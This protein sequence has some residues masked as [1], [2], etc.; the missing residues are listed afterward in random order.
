MARVDLGGG[1]YFDPD[2]VQQ[3]INHL[4]AVLAMMVPDIAKAESLLHVRA[5]GNDPLTAQFHKPMQDAHQ[6]DYKA[7]LDLQAKTKNDVA[8]LE[9]AMKHYLGADEAAK[10]AL[11]AKGQ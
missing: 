6:N 10:Y 7:L 1:T 4:K 9:A 11:S 5:P 8:N 3:A 2:Q